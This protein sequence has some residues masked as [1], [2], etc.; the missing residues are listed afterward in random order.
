MKRKMIH[1]I[2]YISLL[3]L[4]CSSIAFAAIP[5]IL[6]DQG[7]DVKTSSTGELLS[8]GNLTIRIYDSLTGGNLLYEENFTNS[9]NNGSWNVILDDPSLLAD[10]DKTYYKDYIINGDNLNFSGQNRLAFMS[11]LGEIN[12]TSNISLGQKISFNLGEFIQNIITDWIDLV[13]NVN[14][15][16]NLTVM[17]N[18]SIYGTSLTVNNTRVCL[19]D[20][21][22]CQLFGTGAGEPYLYGGGDK[23]L[24]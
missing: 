4:L 12:I 18:V 10:F 11:P 13:G 19:E 21:T 15:T 5:I 23:N 22:N 3:I 7:T 20:G 1:G 2:G 16:K 14:I 9:I 8:L 6:S 17:G 24:S